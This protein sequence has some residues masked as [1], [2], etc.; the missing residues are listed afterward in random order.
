MP[1]IIMKLQKLI[2]YFELSEMTHLNFGKKID[3]LID[4]VINDNQDNMMTN[5]KY[6]VSTL[7]YINLWK[8]NSLIRVSYNV[9]KNL[10]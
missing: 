2:N 3:K 6:L 9:V 4:H 10:N 1:I 8:I 5:L 7:F